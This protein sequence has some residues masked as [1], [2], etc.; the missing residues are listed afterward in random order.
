MLDSDWVVLESEVSC[1]TANLTED[2][3]GKTRRDNKTKT[4]FTFKKSQILT[5]IWS[6]PVDN[7]FVRLIIYVMIQ[8]HVLHV[9]NVDILVTMLSIQNII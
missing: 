8:V 4:E 7:N 2:I 3:P 6:D 5:L 9:R 1:A